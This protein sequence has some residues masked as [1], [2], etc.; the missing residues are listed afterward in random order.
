MIII[1]IHDGHNSGASLFYDNKLICAVTEER[2][3]RKKNEYGFPEKSINFLLKKHNL[4]KK[5]VDLISV[6]TISLSKIFFNKKKYKFKISD[7]FKE[8]EVF[9]IKQFIKKHKLL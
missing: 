6:S 9:Y 8:Q 3:T 2:F 5:S 7:Y 4:S 1:G